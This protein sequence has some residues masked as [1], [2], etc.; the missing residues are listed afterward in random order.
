M[1]RI[2]LSTVSDNLRITPPLKVHRGD[3][4]KLSCHSD[5]DTQW[6][7]QSTNTFP[8][9]TSPIFVIENATFR[10]T[11][12]YFCYGLYSFHGSKHFLAQTSLK[13]YGEFEKYWYNTFIYI[14]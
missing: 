11:G 3:T 10:H 6:Y 14:L 1:K 5:G 12:Q 4:V 7:Y 9:S 2:S 8:I 13:V